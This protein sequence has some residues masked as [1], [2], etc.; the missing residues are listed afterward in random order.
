MIPT[1]SSAGHP[2]VPRRLSSGRG[3]LWVSLTV[4][5][6]FAL[7]SAYVIIAKLGLLYLVAFLPM[8]YLVVFAMV[9][10]FVFD[11]GRGR[12]LATYI[13]LGALIIVVAASLATPGHGYPVALNTSANVCTTVKAVNATA[14]PGVTQYNTTCTSVPSTSL[15]SFG[16]NILYWLPISGLVVY[17]LPGLRAERSRSDKVAFALIGA[18]LIVSLLLPLTGVLVTPG[19]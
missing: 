19:L 1:D 13:L 12:V 8:A 5:A 4:A 9:V 11:S 18:V 3:L 14:P 6:G 16:W 7:F 15:A 10:L 17:S 2:R